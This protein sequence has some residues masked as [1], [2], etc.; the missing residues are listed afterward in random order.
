MKTEKPPT[1]DTGHIRAL[2]FD[3][4]GTLSDTDDLWVH[5]LEP[6]FR[7][8]S[9]LSRRSRSHAFTRWV[10]MGIETPGNL[11]Y[12]WFDRLSLDF[13]LARAYS[14]LVRIRIL[15]RRQKK[16]WA[17][18]GAVEMIR[19][20]HARYPLALVTTRDAH[21]TQCFLEQFGIHDCFTAV[22]TSQTC[23]HTK[24]FPDPVL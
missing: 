13:V 12:H 21:S 23:F 22:A 4:D 17:I 8:L 15:R 5:K 11:M 24:P 20:L 14:T 18:P 19:S 7:P 1:L 3:L 10:L 16:F 2:C 9:S 6:F